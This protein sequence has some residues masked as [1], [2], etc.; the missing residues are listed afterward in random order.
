MTE[1]LKTAKQALGMQTTDA[2]AVDPA[3]DRSHDTPL[4]PHPPLPPLLPLTLSHSSPSVDVLSSRRNL[5]CVLAG[6][7]KVEI[8][9]IGYPKLVSPQG[10]PCPHGVILKVIC[11]AIC[12]SGQRP[13][14]TGAKAHWTPPPHSLTSPPPALSPLQICTCSATARRQETEWCS[15]TVSIQPLAP[16][17]LDLASA[18]PLTVV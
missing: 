3:S 17:A 2:P 16:P 1:L 13:Y 14:P 15:A 10:E 11:S 6:N 12:G 9:D 4:P 7:E 5:A 8:R 18:F